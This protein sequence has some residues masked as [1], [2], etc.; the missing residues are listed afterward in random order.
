MMKIA[1]ILL[2]CAVAPAFGQ[3]QLYTCVEKGR[4]VISNTPCGEGLKLQPTNQT[5]SNVVAP[6]VTPVNALDYSS[7]YGA[8]RGQVQFMAKRGPSVINEAHAVVPLV[9]QIDPQGKVSGASTESGCSFKGIA[10]PGPIETLITLDVTLSG[11]KY[12]GYNRQMTGRVAL[13][14]AKKYVDFSLFANDLIGRPN[15]YYEI[16]GTLRR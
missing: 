9:M 13:Y 4:K 10:I 12:F 8:W 3:Q 6:A 11:C 14:T 7:I 16:K 15:G 5:P 1:V 2:A